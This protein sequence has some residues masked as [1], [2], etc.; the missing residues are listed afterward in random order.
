M[1]SEYHPTLSSRNGRKEG[2]RS[3]ADGD[4][5]VTAG[6]EAGATP[7]ESGGKRCAK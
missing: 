7:N 2:A 1:W 4:V 6:R 5:R 3:N